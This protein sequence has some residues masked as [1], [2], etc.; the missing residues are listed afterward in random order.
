MFKLV[1]IGPSPAPP[2][3]KGLC[4]HS[5][6]EQPAIATRVKLVSSPER[7]D[8]DTA[9]CPENYKTQQP[10]QAWSPFAG[11]S[12]CIHPWTNSSRDILS[13]ADRAASCKYLE[14]S[15]KME[16][17]VASPS[18]GC[19]VV[20]LFWIVRRPLPTARGSALGRDYKQQGAESRNK[21]FRA[22]GKKGTKPRQA[23]S[24]L[25]W[26][27]VSVRPDSRNK[28]PRAKGKKGTKPQHVRSGFRKRH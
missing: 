16:S 28:R 13:A 21:R 14:S 6:C 12:S 20:S 4:F 18:P 7:T 22:K 23:R 25:H 10:Q 5:S 19:C 26:H 15:K 17:K 27:A 11:P 2:I 1:K 8:N 9:N 24:V 3:R